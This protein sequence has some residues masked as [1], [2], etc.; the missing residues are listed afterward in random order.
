MRLNFSLYVRALRVAFCIPLVTLVAAETVLAQTPKPIIDLRPYLVGC[1]PINYNT[2]AGVYFCG[3][4]A[5]VL[6]DTL[7]DVSFSLPFG[8]VTSDTSI[9]AMYQT[10]NPLMSYFILP[11]GASIP[12]TKL[13]PIPTSNTTIKMKV[14]AEVKPSPSTYTSI[15][16]MSAPAGYSVPSMFSIGQKGSSW[17]YGRLIDNPNYNAHAYW[18]TPWEPVDQYPS[19]SYVFEDV[20]YTCNTDGRLRIDVFTPYAGSTGTKYVWQESIQDG[21]W[22]LNSLA[23]D[24][25]V[26]T[27]W[28]VFLYSGNLIL[29]AESA[30][31]VSSFGNNDKSTVPTVSKIGIGEI[32]VYESALSVENM[33]EYAQ[34][35]YP[36]A[37]LAASMSPCN[38]GNWMNGQIGTPCG[39]NQ[40]A[41]QPFP[42]PPSSI[43]PV[44]F[45]K[46]HHPT[47]FALT[48]IGGTWAQFTWTPPATTLT[49]STYTL[50][51]I[52][53]S[54]SG[55][56]VEKLI[57]NGS[58][59]SGSFSNLHSKT[60]YMFYLAASFTSSSAISDLS[61][62]GSSYIQATTTVNAAGPPGYTWCA[63]QGNTCTEPNGQNM[64]TYGDPS[65]YF[66]E[67]ADPGTSYKCDNSLFNGDPDPG[68][69]KS[70]YTGAS[71]FSQP[72]GYTFCNIEP[73]SCDLIGPT[74]LLS[75]AIGS[76]SSFGTWSNYAYMG[77]P[78]NVVQADMICTVAFFGNVNPT[79][80]GRNSCYYKG[81]SSPVN[82]PVCAQEGGTC[83]I[84]GANGGSVYY[85]A[86]DKSTM[87]EFH[88]T[89]QH[90]PQNSEVVCSV[91]AFGI[92]PYPGNTKTCLIQQ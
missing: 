78:N 68:I 16:S 11:A 10:A 13:S 92:D 23:G 62:N 15:L 47:G 27:N 4:N 67:V 55:Y 39:Q 85:G 12:L 86:Y 33:I 7:S 5:A 56:T 75:M 22:P 65:H 51:A 18:M 14:M 70:C 53:S 61:D 28:S 83:K 3:T 74:S 82:Y 19:Q 25:D 79:P 63:D 6:K 50:Y 44:D 66:A 73:G 37:F 46:S 52:P 29:G 81:N 26:T 64:I 34:A 43:N 17:T 30:S 84:T 2:G 80:G 58:A 20:Y 32:A 36:S 40:G 60:Q 71:N 57:I 9:A 24:I 1:I 35:D 77:N 41:H 72:N 76:S 38:S 21:G 42:A 45:F 89:F 69:P 88:Y 8:T 87:P 31:G 48:S 90:F 59:T 91:S 54:Q 49:P